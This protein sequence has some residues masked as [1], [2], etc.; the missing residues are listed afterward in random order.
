[1]KSE[2]VANLVLELDDDA[3]KKEGAAVTT[4]KHSPE[5]QWPNILATVSPFWLVW[6]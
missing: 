3:T 5:S 6:I 1:M 2:G 4:L